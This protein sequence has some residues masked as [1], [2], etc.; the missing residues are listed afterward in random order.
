[1]CVLWCFDM[2]D[3]DESEMNR[4]CQFTNKLAFLYW[5]TIA[6]EIFNKY[7]ALGQFG[8]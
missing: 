2:G 6:M 4:S 3:F 7:K 8:N 5:R 1:M